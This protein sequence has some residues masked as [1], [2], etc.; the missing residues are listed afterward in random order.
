MSTIDL[1]DI[2]PKLLENLNFSEYLRHLGYVKRPSPKE[3]FE[4]YTFNSDTFK[5]MLFLSSMNGTEKYHSLALNDSGDIIRFTQNRYELLNPE[6]TFSPN[7]DHLIEAV[8]Q[9]LQY[10]IEFGITD[11][12]LD[13]NKVDVFQFQ[14]MQQSGFT[15]FYSC[16]TLF[17]YKYL[18]SIYI[19][20]STYNH[21]IFE[22]KIYNT[23]GLV[24]NNEEFQVVNIAYPLTD[25]NDVEYGLQYE[26]TIVQ[27]KGGKVQQKDISFFA[28]NSVK[29]F[30]WISNT[31]QKKSNEKLHLTI[32]NGATESLAHFSFFREK[33]K[34]IGLYEY[35]ENTLWNLKQFINRETIVYL[36]LDISIESFKMELQIICDLLEHDIHII[37]DVVTHLFFSINLNEEQYFKRFLN[38]IQNFNRSVGKDILNRLGSESAPYLKSQE[39]QVS[40]QQNSLEVKIPKN[41]KTLYFFEKA[42]VKYFPN[43]IPINFDKP[44]YLN[45]KTQNMILQ[46]SIQGN[47]EEYE[48]YKSEATVFTT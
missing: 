34:Y 12:T 44:K 43:H 36:A 2:I 18:E 5:D 19:P 13:K 15:T 37:K 7:K 22:D 29:S 10:S 8:S 48:R 28:E 16:K 25:F 3:G 24:Y 20:D 33:R 47:E 9:L 39:I 41:H 6:Q 11:K 30:F 17:E 46:K 27:R 40:E 42:L 35:S 38:A 26:N 45:W 32:T 31:P 1:Y 14:Q 4:Y 23:I 21:P